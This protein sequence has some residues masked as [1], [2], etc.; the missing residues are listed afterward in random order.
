ME[1]VFYLR[2][3]GSL[4]PKKPAEGT[5]GQDSLLA[6]PASPCLPPASP[7]L[8]LLMELWYQAGKKR[9]NSSTLG[10]TDLLNTLDPIIAF[11]QH[12]F[13]GFLLLLK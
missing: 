3:R 12:L 5:K 4:V 2:A 6:P 1:D 11:G 10:Q 9:A 13:G 8:F 7:A